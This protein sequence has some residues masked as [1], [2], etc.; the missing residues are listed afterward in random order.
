M[1]NVDKIAIK[2]SKILINNEHFIPLDDTQRVILNWY[3]G[4]KTYEHIP[5]WEIV[6]AQKNND[7][8]YIEK[9]KNKI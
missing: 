9:F 5:M 7:L 2:N 6:E 3:G 1:Y 8:N 4:A